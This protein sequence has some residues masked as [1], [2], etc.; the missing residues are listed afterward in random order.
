VSGDEDDDPPVVLPTEDFLD[1][2]AFAPRDVRDVVE[3]YLEAA[4]QAGFE[5]VRLIH[6][7]GAGVQRSIVRSLLSRHPAV[8]AFADAPPDRGG[9]GA[10]LVRLHPDLTEP[11]AEPT[12]REPEGR[13]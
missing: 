13:E 1:L 11:D 2:H 10:T 8:A 5:E 9:W 3:S 7:R 12:M 4:V 6:G